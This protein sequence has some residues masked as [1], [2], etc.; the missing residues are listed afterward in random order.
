[1]KKSYINGIG[2]I[3]AQKTVDSNFLSEIEINTTETVLNAKQ[4]SY[5]EVISPSFIRRMAKG[6]KMGIFT[7]TQALKEANLE[8][9]DAIITG[10][11]LGC[12]EDSEKFLKA[13]LDN[14]E[15][16]LTPTS[17]I[18]S[19]HN[20]V[21][22][23]IALG[24]Q[25]KGYNFTY[26][27]G[28][29]SFETALLDAKL[30]IESDEANSVLVGGIDETAQHNIDVQRI[31]GK[32]KKQEDVPF[33]VLNPTSKGMILSEGASF[34]VLENQ[35]KESSYATLEAI[36]ILN[37]LEVD[38][39]QGYVKTF[40]S[41]N[42]I[43][44]NDI[45]L[46]VLGNNGDVE[47]DVYFNQVSDLFNTTSQAYYKHLSGEFYTASG[48]GLWMAS[49]ILKLQTI[50]ADVKMNSVEKGNYQTVLL[51]NQYRGKDHSLT[52]IKKC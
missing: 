48:F 24:L 40:L 26:V 27:N 6:V 28:A 4:P 12:L 30:Q 29:V 2:C 7:S 16:F 5:T 8:V 3:S 17:F 38:E 43:N 42:K 39:V 19:T 10:T 13:I 41:D 23:Q 15:Q 46:V 36:S 20:T 18:Q 52:L 37:S 31:A 1:M 9:P 22:G 14:N 34:F 47:F 35:Q 11:G 21:A 32:I 49:N 45:D 51:Y 25:C 33:S 50:P 44:P